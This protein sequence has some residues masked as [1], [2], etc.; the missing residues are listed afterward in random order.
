MP[1]MRMVF[2]L[3]DTWWNVNMHQKRV[4]RSLWRVLIDTWWNV[5]LAV[6]IIVA[7][8]GGVL[9]DTWWNV[10]R[11]EISVPTSSFAF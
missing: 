5:N 11:C 7:E 2:V 8:V 4:N 10:N 1:L 9:I 3:I 6:G